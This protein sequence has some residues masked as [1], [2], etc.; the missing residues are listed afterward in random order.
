VVNTRAAADLLAP[1]KMDRPEDIEHSPINGKV[2]MVMTN[3]TRRG[4]ED[5]PATDNANPRP[6]NAFGHIIEVTEDGDDHAATTFV[7]DMF[8]LAGDP[9]DES[10]YFAGFP[11]EKVSKIANPDNITFDADGNLWISTDGQPSSLEINDGLFAVPTDGADRGYLRQFFSSVT[12][13]E[14][15]GPIFTPDNTA[16]FLS[17]Q[18]PGEGGTYDE[19]TTSWPGTSGAPR[20][21]LVLIQHETGGKIGS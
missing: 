20:P 3:N 4:V 14:V 19:P 7:W 6:D 9:A 5:N 11:K 21:G 15:S 12:G 2:Y 17:V 8:L 13:S 10:T 18:H 1:T 16:L